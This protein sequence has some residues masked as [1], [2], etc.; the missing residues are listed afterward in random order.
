MQILWATATAGV[1]DGACRL[2]TCYSSNLDM[3]E[4]L[5]ADF[6]RPPKPPTCRHALLY[7]YS[8]VMRRLKPEADLPAGAMACVETPTQ[9]SQCL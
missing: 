1:L 9:F 3:A 2:K 5:P 7:D 8:V 6:S 4:L